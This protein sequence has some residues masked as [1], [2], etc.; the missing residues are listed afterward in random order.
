[1][2]Y[3]IIAILLTIPFCGTAQEKG[4]RFL[5]GQSWLE[6]Q[7]RAN[8]EKK[9]IFIDAFATWCMPCKKMDAIVYTDE[10]VGSYFN[11]HFI[12]VKVQMDRT[13]IDPEIV[14]RW[15]IE[16]TRM[17]KDFHIEAFPTFLFL[18]A[19]G[20]LVNK[21]TG[22][23]NK[24]DFLTI[25]RNAVDP[26]ENFS[27]QVSKF[28]NGKLNFTD[29]ESLSLTARRYKEDSLARKIATKFKIGFLNK[30]KLSILLTKQHSEFLIN[31]TGV[32]N[33]DDPLVEYIYRNQE[34]V[35]LALK[36]KQISRNLTDYLISNA[37]FNE[38]SIPP[39]LDHYGEPNW[40]LIEKKIA[41]R[42][43]LKTA[44]RV[45]LGQKVS[46]YTKAKNWS[47]AIKYQIEQTDLSGPDTA[48]M[49]KV[50]L[51]NFAYSMIF[52]HATDQNH[53][54]KGIQYMELIL[55]SDSTSFPW[56]DT[57]ANLLY[58]AGNKTAGIEQEQKA[59][60][61]AKKDND[62]GNIKEFEDNLKNMKEGLPTWS[63]H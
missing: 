59:I 56:I 42:Y 53:L 15:Y 14:R 36:S 11:A 51:N 62:L 6:I 37:F 44:H 28:R 55:K 17:Q 60:F 61:Y 57:Y 5:N 9:L 13:K 38:K 49:A 41:D 18:S 23:K 12:S 27:V 30:Q 19:D 39:N 35:D 29:M 8:S 63:D 34:E 16:A 45:T 21:E 24:Y 25:A 20:K 32:F 2:R 33:I 58:K 47:N 40:D 7:K 50:F 46:W 31:F 52:Q 48:G 10:S 54:K 1:M 43:D 4:I 3:I 26:K 22:F